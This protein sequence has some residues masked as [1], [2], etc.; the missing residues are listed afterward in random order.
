MT[1]GGHALSPECRAVLERL[2]DYFNR[3]D[4]TADEVEH[5]RRHL[6]ACPPCE[7]ISAFEE[8][9]LARLRASGPCACPDRLRARVK[10]LLEIP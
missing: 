6:S 2:H 10:A 9:L 7:E 1:C 4:L 3:R 5:I 8:A